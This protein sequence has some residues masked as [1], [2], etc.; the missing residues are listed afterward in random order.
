[1]EHAICMK[2]S[3]LPSIGE[4]V[5]YNQ[6]VTKKNNH[7]KSHISTITDYRHFLLTSAVIE[8]V[9]SRIPTS[10]HRNSFFPYG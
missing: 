5:L 6:L 8:L 2:E 4:R 10:K 7:K 3:M 9:F 1:M